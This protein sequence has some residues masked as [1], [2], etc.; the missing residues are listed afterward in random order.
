MPM[1][2]IQGGTILLNV[3][4]I[5]KKLDIKASYTVA[6]LGCGGGGHFVAP[7]AQLVGKTG[8]VYALDVQKGVLDVVRGKMK[9]HH[10]TNVEY[11]WSN[12]EKYGAAA[13]PDASCDL[14]L[15]I[16]VLFQNTTHETI[17]KESARFLHSGGRL[18]IIDWK[19]TPSPFGPP[20]HIRVDQKK[21]KDLGFSL[22]LTWFDEFDAGPYHFGLTFRKDS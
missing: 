22:S 8:K 17:L 6:D 12:L 10:I 20:Q 18:V 9:Q 11:I 7:L 2:D 15:L 14:A 19:H 16:N 13:I 21:L 4:E 5:I 3:Y 1:Q